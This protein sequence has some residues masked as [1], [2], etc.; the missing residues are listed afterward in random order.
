MIKIMTRI[1]GIFL[2]VILVGCDSKKEIRTH[3]HIV[4][5]TLSTPVKHLYFS[6]TIQPINT[7]SVLSPVQGNVE[8]INFMYGQYVKQGQ[9]LAIINSVKLMDDFRSA[10]S[11]FLGKKTAYFTQLKSFEGT[12]VLYK[13]GVIDRD[14]FQSEQN[15]Y[16]NSVLDYFEQEYQLKK[17]LLKA[18]IAPSLVEKLTITDIADIKKLFGQEINHVKIY[19]PS[20]GVALFPLTQNSPT[21]ENNSSQNSSSDTITTGSSIHESQLILSIGN[22]SGFSIDMAISEIDINSL[23]QGMTAFVSGDAFPG[24]TLKGVVSYVASQAQPNQGG[25]SSL[26][27]FRASVQVPQV[28]ADTL[29]TVHVGMTAKVDIPIRQ[30]PRIMLPI[31]A[32]FQKNDHNYVTIVDALGHKKDVVI[33]VGNTTLNEVAILSGVQAGQK[34]IV[35]D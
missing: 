22:L 7:V 20:T 25:A 31:A 15:Q 5:A 9:L 13:A 28:Q 10:V 26:S 4:I 24:I 29:L 19:A 3:E 16:E 27:V 32:V 6:G 33:A 1:F 2:M 12:Q 11:S 18:G 14:T 21:G 34:V 17:V 23:H 35:Y 8:N 30:K